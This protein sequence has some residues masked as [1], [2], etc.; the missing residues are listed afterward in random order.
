MLDAACE[1]ADGV[2]V[3]ALEII[4]N[5]FTIAAYAAFGIN[6]AMGR[7]PKRIVNENIF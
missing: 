7:K 2:D 6:A 3:M 1:G 5:I 4:L